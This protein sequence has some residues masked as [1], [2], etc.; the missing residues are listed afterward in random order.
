MKYKTIILSFLAQSSLLF[1]ADTVRLNTDFAN[2]A[3][4]AT[5][6]TTLSLNV[7]VP[8]NQP[9]DEANAPKVYVPLKNTGGGSDTTEFYLYSKGGVP[10]ILNTT[11]TSYTINYPVV[12][13]VGSS[14]RY[15][16][17][18]AYDTDA[19]QWEVVKMYPTTLISLTN[20][21]LTFPVSPKSICDQTATACTNLGVGT[22]T[23]T[24][25]DIKL[26]FFLHSTNSLAAGAVIDPATYTEGIYIVTSMSNVIQ[27]PSAYQ[28]NI[29]S[30]R[31][32][33]KRVVL[34]VANTA[35]NLARSI[36]VLNLPSNSVP[37]DRA[38]GDPALGAY[39][40]LNESYPYTTEGEITVRELVNGQT[41]NLA[42]VVVDKYN[43]A[44]PISDTEVASPA[45]IEE[46]LKENKC[47][48][49]TAGFGE[50]HPIIDYF[51]HFRD[52]V[53]KNNWAGRQVIKSYYDWGP[54]AALY[55]YDSEFL[56]L[57]VRGI[58]HILYFAFSHI[59]L[60]LLGAVLIP[61]AY[62]ILFT[63]RKIKTQRL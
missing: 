28:G 53:L 18:A 23:R 25:K 27:E 39:T 46:L 8:T 5:T 4:T 61:G 24:T 2:F 62:L 29:V 41:Y 6:T 10:D 58:A 16:Y 60:M 63:L 31:R 57:V 45:Q 7:D 37:A 54:K 14:N 47:F 52:A 50:N 13:T 15:L 17:V 26:Y 20:A 40:L 48:L 38:I 43:F 32:G 11:S 19:P 51:R 30:Q 44:T 33:D 56:R 49:L 35:V 9:T 36:R 55:L 22:A 42:Y 12:V 1:A 3:V 34:S 21:A 59:Y